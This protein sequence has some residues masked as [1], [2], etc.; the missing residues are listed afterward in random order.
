M[1]FP[2]WCVVATAL[3]PY[4]LSS[5]AGY[6]RTRQFGT[7]DNNDPRA[8]AARLEGTGA[9]AYAAHQNAMEALP[10]FTAAVV[11]AHLAGA[12]P[13]LS[14]I[15]A[16]IFVVTRILHPIF[17]ITNVAPAR[18]A[19]FLVGLGCCIWLFALAARA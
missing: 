4:F 6:F 15:A 12:D 19:A 10:I 14:S 7:L 2:F 1:T 18:S 3:L 16:G 8:Q 17:Y 13:G 9:R 5:A 11:I